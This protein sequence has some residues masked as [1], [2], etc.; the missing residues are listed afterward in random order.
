[1][2]LSRMF[3]PNPA[4]PTSRDGGFLLNIRKVFWYAVT[5]CVAIV[6]WGSVAPDNLNNVRE[7]MTVFVY[8]RF[9]WFYMLVII[10]MNILVY[11]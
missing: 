10:A 7:A 8:N 3:S 2:I 1:M 5:I 4:H 11:I 6:I 9:G